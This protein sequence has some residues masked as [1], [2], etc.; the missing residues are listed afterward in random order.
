MRLGSGNRSP[1]TR[2]AVGEAVDSVFL[3]QLSTEL[4]LMRGRLVRC[5]ENGFLGPHVLLRM[6]VAVQA[7]T[8]LQ[9]GYGPGQR[10]FPDGTVAC[11]AADPLGQVNTVVKV[12]ELR[13]IV[14]AH[15]LDGSILAKAGSHR[16]EHRAVFPDL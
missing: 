2:V 4:D 8:H 11:R 3:D 16:L 7:P 13:N 1:V 10:H 6:A 15:P 12:N 14:H 5:A 9:C